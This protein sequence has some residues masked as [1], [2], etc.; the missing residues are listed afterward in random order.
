ME[1]YIRL[2]GRLQKHCNILLDVRVPQYT[3]NTRSLVGIM[4]QHCSDK[5][6]QIYTVN[7]RHSRHLKNQDIKSC[8]IF[9]KIIVKL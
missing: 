5:I 7:L 6:T 4:I 9:H 2:F 3:I 1:N 8:Y